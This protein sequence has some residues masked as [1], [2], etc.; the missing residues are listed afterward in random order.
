[1]ESRY[2]SLTDK[3][4]LLNAAKEAEIARLMEL[5]AEIAAFRVSPGS[6][7]GRGGGQASRGG[8]GA[9]RG[10]GSGA[11]WFNQKQQSQ[12]QQAQGQS[13]E[14][15]HWEK[16]RLRKNWIICHKCYQW[17]KHRQMSV[18]FRLPRSRSLLPRT[19]I[20]DQL[21]C[22]LTLNLTQKTRNRGVPAAVT[23][24]WGLAVDGVCMF[25]VCYS[26]C[27]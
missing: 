20:S 3:V 11:P 18:S 9:L 6:S 21:V 7:P 10:G 22:R 19:G 26:L 15:T 13:S 1:M 27:T 8:Q 23:T 14:L 2:A 24:R 5:E 25:S 4:M 12:P 16:I 17:G